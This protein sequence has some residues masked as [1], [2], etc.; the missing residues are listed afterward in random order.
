MLV[1]ILSAAFAATLSLWH[2]RR[3]PLA[4][5]SALLTLVFAY[6]LIDNCIERPDGLIIG[7]VFTLL[8]MLA[9]GISRSMRSMEFRIPYGFFVDIESWTLGP[10]A[11]WQEGPPRCQ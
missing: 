8:L 11:S 2:E 7:T 10:D 9:C 3:Y 1:L 5:Y 6:T 4:I